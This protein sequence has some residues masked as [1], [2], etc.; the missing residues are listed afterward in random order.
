MV[1]CDRYE[2][3]SVLILRLRDA[4][5][6]TRSHHFSFN[7]AAQHSICDTKQAR[8]NVNKNAQGVIRGAR[9]HW[10]MLLHGIES[11]L[12]DEVFVTPEE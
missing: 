10:T 5:E 12:V 9:I 8:A 7:C 11:G 1:S 4:R 6:F 2:R 3:L